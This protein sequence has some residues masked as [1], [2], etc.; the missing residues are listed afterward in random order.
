MYKNKHSIK[1]SLQDVTLLPLWIFLSAAVWWRSQLLSHMAF[2][3]LIFLEASTVSL[4]SQC[5]SWSYLWCKLSLMFISYGYTLETKSSW[6]F[7]FTICSWALLNNKV[8]SIFLFFTASLCFDG[9]RGRVEQRGLEWR[10]MCQMVYS[11]CF[12]LSK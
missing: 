11:N 10:L 5:K 9:N 6:T 4:H 12:I 8:N 1:L 2:A 3:C 7:R